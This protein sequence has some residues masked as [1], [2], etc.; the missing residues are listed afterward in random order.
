MKKNYPLRRLYLDL[1]Y[2]LIL[3]FVFNLSNFVTAQSQ[4][5]KVGFEIANNRNMKYAGKSGAHFKFIVTNKSSRADTYII[6]V[7]NSEDSSLNEQKANYKGRRMNLPAKIDLDTKGKNIHT[8]NKMHL[9]T[10]EQNNLEVI[11]NPNEDILIVVN[12]E[13]PEGTEIGGTNTTNV[14]LKSTNCKNVSITKQIFTET[15]DGE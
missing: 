15:V 5:C 9:K 10:S 1:R 3:V 2:F 7:G 13:V 4:D 11:L 12:I 8:S 6:S 14:T